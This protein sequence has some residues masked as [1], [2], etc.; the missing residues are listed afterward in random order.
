MLLSRRLQSL[1]E[2]N[3]VGIVRMLDIFIDSRI[4][5]LKYGMER[6]AREKGIDLASAYSEIE[7]VFKWKEMAIEKALQLY[8]VN[9]AETESAEK[10]KKVLE[11]MRDYCQAVFMST[12]HIQ[13]LWGKLKDDTEYL[14]EK[15]YEYLYDLYPPLFPSIVSAIDAMEPQQIEEF[16]AGLQKSVPTAV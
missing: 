3:I 1:D 2:R 6:L 4:N 14:V 10:V 16:F 15:M 13:R 11:L 9:K 8:A 7:H 12:E 5:Y